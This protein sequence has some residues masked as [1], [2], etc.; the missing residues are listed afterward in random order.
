MKLIRPV[1]TSLALLAAAAS[2]QATIVVTISANVLADELGVALPSGTLIQLV[3][4]G[5]DGIFN[6]ISVEDGDIAG[7]NQW[8]SGDDSVINVT[9]LDPFSEPPAPD[10]Q[11]PNTS[12]FDLSNGADVPGKL[13]RQFLFDDTAV[14]AN[15]KIGIRWFPDLQASTFSG[16]TLQ[17]GQFYGQFTRLSG[18]L[19]EE[20]NTSPWIW[21]DAG[22][23]VIFDPLKTTAGGEDPATS[24]YAV[25]IVPEPASLGLAFLGAVGL[26]SLRK[27]RR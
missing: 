19:Y 26:L 12:A 24:G 15:S 3:N 7:L 1:I 20:N 17:N 23:E 16:L 2:S 22:A 6:P 9:F 4:L 8:V 11:F 13:L 25:H 27:R 10:P 18:L 14:P 21:P 5:A